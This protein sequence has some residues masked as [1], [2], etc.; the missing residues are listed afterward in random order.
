MSD[1]NNTKIITPSL[2]Q[3]VDYT[4]ALKIGDEFYVNGIGGD[5][6]PGESKVISVYNPTP[7]SQIQFTSPRN[8]AADI[9]DEW[10]ITSSSILN[11]TNSPYN[12]FTDSTADGDDWHS[13]SQGLP[14]WIQWQCTYKK[15]LVKSYF[16]RASR[17]DGYT[18]L[19]P[20]TWKLQGSDD[21]QNW[22]DLDSV[23]VQGGNQRGNTV[24]RLNLA[25]NTS[26]Y[27]H[28]IYITAVDG[29]TSQSYATCNCIVAT[30]SSQ[31]Y[32][33]IP[34]YDVRDATAIA[35]DIRAGS[36]AY[37]KAGRTIGTWV[38]P[39]EITA[40][41]NA[42]YRCA[43]AGDPATK[44]WSGYKATLVDGKY[45]FENTLTSGLS[46][47][48]N[49]PRLGKIYTGDALV[50]V[51]GLYEGMP[52]SDMVFYAPLATATSTAVTGQPVEQYNTG[53]S[54][55]PDHAVIDGI[56][57]VHIKNTGGG[58]KLYKVPQ[59]SI[60]KDFPV[61]AQDRTLS[62]WIKV[63]SYNNSDTA[64]MGYGSGSS[65]CAFTFKVQSGKFEVDIYNNSVMCTTAVDVATWH[66]VTAVVKD[67]VLSIYVDGALS[68]SGELP[69][70]NTNINDSFYIGRSLSAWSAIWEGYLAAPRVYKYALAADEVAKLATEFTPV[71]TA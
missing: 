29:S 22:T 2:D 24:M 53:S 33:V 11:D 27:Y 38:M 58:Y 36:V 6:I 39:T 14:A 61:Y 25:N 34:K 16:L 19:S 37:T 63:L 35:S 45:T 55:T 7:E 3:I 15:V 44:K 60:K 18:K 21:G 17:R 8:P 48:S 49:Y 57:C 28:R 52:F 66:C 10:I 5:Y 43:V 41:S 62:V 1:I 51:S 13:A 47:T 59:D 20:S 70:M 71:T 56:P 46:F 40:E 50:E 69:N 32:G 64:F 42:Y 30:N 68:R 12:A 31:I 65:N 26:Y 9:S 54:Y 4:P 67:K 23:T